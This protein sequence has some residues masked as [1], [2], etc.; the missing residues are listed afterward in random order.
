MHEHAGRVEDAAERRPPCRRERLGEPRR[1]GRPGRRRPGSP[2]ARARA[3][4]APPRPRAGR[5]T[6]R[7]ELV[8]RWQVAQPHGNECKA[9]CSGYFASRETRRARSRLPC[10]PALAGGGRGASP[11]AMPSTGRSRSRA[12][13]SREV[14]AA[15]GRSRSSSTA[16]R[17]E[18]RPA[19]STAAR[20]ARRPSRRSGTAGR[21]LVPPPDAAA[22]R[23]EPAGARR[24]SGARRRG[25][26][27]D[28]VA[29]RVSAA[30]PKPRRAQV[31]AATAAFRRHPPRDR[32]TPSTPTPA[33]RVARE[34]GADR[35]A[36]AVA[37]TD[38]RRARR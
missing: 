19:R 27:C 16:R 2:R 36:H 11:R 29:A 24:R 35:R 15:D 21:R 38:P 33:R 25:P 5:R 18:V 22:R 37:R 32:A 28:D 26:G 30:L 1:A 6:P 17:Y 7:D 13:S 10:S 8:D 23:P 20:R 31:V 12:S 14:D 3:R 34:G 9:A 4:P